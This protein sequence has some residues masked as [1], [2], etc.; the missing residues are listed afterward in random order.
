MPATKISIARRRPPARGFTLIE[1]IVVAGVIVLLASLLVP[2][3]AKAYKS[4]VRSRMLADLHVLSQGLEAYKLDQRDYPRIYA[5]PANQNTDPRVDGAI[6][7]CWAL[8]APGPDI[9]AGGQPGGDGANG[10]GFRQRGTSGTVY[11]PYVAPEKFRMGLPADGS[12][13]S[14][15]LR[16]AILDRNDKPIYYCPAR[17]NGASYINQPGGFVAD[18]SGTGMQPMYDHAYFIDPNQNPVIDLAVMQHALGD[19]NA[20]GYID[21]GEQAAF[22]GPYI[23]WAAGVDQNYNNFKS[24]VTNLV[25]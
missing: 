1:L 14:D 23:L 9:I 25:Q 24:N 2:M 3:L 16:T 18:Y 15:N 6:L 4:S 13:S 12:P 11:G 8:I 20:N 5:N 21:N 19:A 17:P 10:P 22:T 7:L